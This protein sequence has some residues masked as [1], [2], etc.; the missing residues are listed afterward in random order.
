MAVALSDRQRGVLAA[1]CDTLLP[2]LAREP[3]PGGYFAAGALATG[4]PARVERMLAELPDDQDRRRLA[5]LL[6]V[7]DS[8]VAALA[9]GAGFARFRDLPAER[10]ERV[11]RAWA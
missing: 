1:I 6:R 5:M 2:S 3:D 8:P 10:R 9:A 11:L 4:T 7:L